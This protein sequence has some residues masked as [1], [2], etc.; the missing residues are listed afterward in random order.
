[1]VQNQLS[2]V[3]SVYEQHGRAF[4]CKNSP[5]LLFSPLKLSKLI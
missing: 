1:M 5:G 2:V 3:S 4:L